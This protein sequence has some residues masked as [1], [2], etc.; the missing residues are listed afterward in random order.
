LKDNDFLD[1]SRGNFG[2]A[3]FA[4]VTDGMD[5]VDKIAAVETGR[6]HGFDDVPVEP[7]IMKSVRRVPQ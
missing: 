3:V 7:V 4:K 6:K 1:H 5:V 2:Y